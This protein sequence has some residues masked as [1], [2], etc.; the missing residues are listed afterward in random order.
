MHGSLGKEHPFVFVFVGQMTPLSTKQKQHVKIN[1]VA[2]S[3]QLTFTLKTWY[4][5]KLFIL[6]C[7]ILEDINCGRSRS[8]E[9]YPPPPIL[10]H[11]SL[12]L[13]PA[14]SHN[15]VQFRNKFHFL[16]HGKVWSWRIYTHHCTSFFRKRVSTPA[17]SSAV[18][19]LVNF[20]KMISISSTFIY[21]LYMYLSRLV[22]AY[23][24]H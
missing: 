4:H 12:P 16:K 19:T 18:H 13:Y 17:W 22:C 15:R 11:P 24:S 14:C 6:N 3:T 7:N 9:W 8:H 2:F 23:C 21:A 20:Q 5:I 1:F 10:P